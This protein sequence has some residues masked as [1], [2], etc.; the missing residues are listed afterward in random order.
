MTLEVVPS[1]PLFWNATDALIEQKMYI[2]I[3]TPVNDTLFKL[4]GYADKNDPYWSY[5]ESSRHCISFRDLP[6]ILSYDD[7]KTY[8]RYNDYKHDSCSL[9]DPG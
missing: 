2:S 9:N 4:S 6:Q 7:F 5:S 1:M 8:V 3:N